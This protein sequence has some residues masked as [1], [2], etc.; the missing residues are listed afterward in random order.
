P[1]LSHMSALVNG[2]VVGTVPLQP[3]N[4]GGLKVEI[5]VN[6]AMF[7]RHNRVGVRV[8]GHYTRDCE[9]PV[10]SSLWAI[11]NNATSLELTLQALPPATDL[12]ALP[13]PFF[14]TAERKPLRLPFALPANPSSGVLR[15]AAVVAGYF[16]KEAG[17]R[18]ADFPVE[19]GS[20]GPGDHVVLATPQ[21]LPRGI[22]LP[23]ILGPTISNI[24]N[25]AG[26]RL[27]LIA[28]RND[29]ELHAAA[30]TLALGSV[31]LSGASM[32]VGTPS[33]RPRGAY[34]APSWLPDDRP[35]RF[36]ELVEPDTLQGF[37]LIPGPLTVPF[38]TAPDLFVWSDRGLPMV[39]RY[40]Y[41][42]GDWLDLERSRLDVSINGQYLKSLPVDAPNVVDEVREIVSDDFVLNE[43]QVKV[44]PFDIGGRNQIDLFYDMRPKKRGACQDVLPTNIISSIDPDS[45]IDIS[46]AERFAVMPNLGFFASAGFP[47]T[48]YA[49]LG[50][51]A[52]VLPTRPTAPEIQAFLGL[53]GRFAE[54]TGF[55]PLA[56]TV[57][58]GTGDVT[59]LQGRDV[60][61]VGTLGDRLDLD[62]IGGDG[63]LIFQG[64][65]MTLATGRSIDRAYALLDGDGWTD[66]RQRAGEL[67]MA[68]TGFAGIIGEQARGGPGERSVIMVV[69][70][71]GERLPALVKALSQS[72]INAA[73]QGDLAVFDGAGVRSFRIG[74]TYTVGELGFYG[75]LR[76]YFRNK[77]LLL[78]VVSL[79][80]VALI[81]IVFYT[82]LRLI[83]KARLR[84]KAGA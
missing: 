82:F 49:D 11:V 5:P 25:G 8:I 16:A 29:E 58:Q 9:D 15:A 81:G 40:R 14:D 77:P 38:R 4:A 47:F 46:A 63:P 27:L 20:F 65:K 72:E 3:Q 78:A 2:V 54:F 26:G 32:T 69:A 70:N 13:S 60:L 53:M 76:W 33:I 10:H 52:V 17:Y 57:L 71:D 67:L 23:N 18:G 39:V 28:G 21:A 84:R 73:V 22:T 19:T 31:A 37:G 34:D 12:A 50:R 35:V 43:G 1:D 44:P 59:P 61:V 74:P 55:P 24:A 45:T 80:A 62:Y 42:R 64:N 6:P 51:T 56:V 41:P 66:Q 79:L 75:E 30:T 68:G 83:T 48:V 7:V 36:G